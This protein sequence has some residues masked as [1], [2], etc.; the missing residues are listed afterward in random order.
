MRSIK[1]RLSA[2]LILTLVVVFG[3]QWALVSLTIR[4]VTEDYVA[5]RLQFDIEGVL[6]ALEFD[7][8]GQPLLTGRT[9][10]TAFQR[11]FSGHYYQVQSGGQ[12]LR[13]RSLWDKELPLEALAAGQRHRYRADGPRDQP[14]L[15]VAEAFVKQ[16]RP[17]TVASAEDISRI[18]RDISRLQLGY[19]GLSGL[20]LG[21]LVLLQRWS[22]SRALMP[23]EAV[24]ADLRK[25]AEGSTRRMSEAVPEEI[26]PLAREINRLLELL[27]RRLGQTRTALGNLAHALK[28]PLTVIMQLTREPLLQD[29]PELQARLLA[30]TRTIGTLVER[31]LKRARLAGSGSP[32]ARFDPGSDATALVAVLDR[33][34]ADR[35]LDIQLRI[36]GEE[37]TAA[38]RED[39]MELLGNLADNA[40][41]WARARVAISVVLGGELILRVEDDG[42][43]CPPET[44]DRLIQ[45]GLRLDETTEG[46]GLGL[47][48]AR[49][50]VDYYGGRLR[51]CPSASLGGL[52]A[53]ARIPN[54]EAA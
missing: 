35:A 25:L 54:R 53:E 17:V 37:A 50:I 38:D 24:R 32:G 23:L 12:L 13:S 9:L 45:R 22:V 6:A 26:G 30:Q 42:P 21:L 44:L 4:K 47:A 39:M 11:P 40:C 5:G 48:I 16:G 7:I 46:H 10:D 43:G 28:T 51:F 1:G 8:T 27:S 15:V 20:L 2:S 31:E 41:K 29:N 33:I 36:E 3:L 49:D 19:L 18:Q 34:H 52:C 14:L